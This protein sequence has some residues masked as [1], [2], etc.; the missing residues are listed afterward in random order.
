M[1]RQRPDTGEYQVNRRQFLIKVITGVAL[2]TGATGLAV[3]TGRNILNAEK[4]KQRVWRGEILAREVECRNLGY[5]SEENKVSNKN[6]DWVPEQVEEVNKLER[7]SIIAGAIGEAIIAGIAC[8]AFNKRIS[9]LFERG[10][11]LSETPP[12]K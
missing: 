11:N 7:E 3:G 12:P 4:A 6:Q 10:N 9:V 8:L 1:E 5:I 2:G